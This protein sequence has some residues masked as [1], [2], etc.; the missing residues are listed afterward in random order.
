MLY[1]PLWEQQTKADPKS[2]QTFIGWLETKNP[3]ETYNY[4]DCSGGCLIG[5]YMTATGVGWSHGEYNRQP[6]GFHLIFG[7]VAIGHP[8]TFGAAL[9]RA[10]AKAR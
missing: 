7:D 1:D 4:M 8:Q 10:R 5:Q 9:E 6:D 2:I 3:H